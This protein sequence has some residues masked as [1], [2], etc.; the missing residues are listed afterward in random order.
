MRRHVTG[1]AARPETGSLVDLLLRGSH[2]TRLG[3]ERQTLAAHRDPS[4][5]VSKIENLAFQDD[6]PHGPAVRRGGGGRPDGS[7]CLWV[8]RLAS[9]GGCRNT[10]SHGHGDDCGRKPSV[11]A[12]APL[13]VAVAW[14]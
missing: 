2:A 3:W 6:A 8:A 1:A 9:G 12:T 4:A 13:R 5:A 14:V 10:H 7:R 11:N